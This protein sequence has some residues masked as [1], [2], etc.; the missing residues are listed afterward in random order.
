MS[1]FRPCSSV[2]NFSDLSMTALNH[3]AN[4]T[5]VT[6]PYLDWRRQ[7]CPPPFPPRVFAK[8]LKNG[9]TD[10]HQTLQLLYRTLYWSSV[11]IKSLGDCLGERLAKNMIKEGN[12]PK[13]FSDSSQ[14]RL[15]LGRNIRWAVILSNLKEVDDVISNLKDN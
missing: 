6:Q 2:L 7:N 8:Y 11:N 10:L 3:S 9:S 14:L 1:K 15:K 13:K 5:Q 4:S 12:F